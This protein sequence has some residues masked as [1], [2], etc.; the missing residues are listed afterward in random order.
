MSLGLSKLSW[1]QA[2]PASKM[3]SFKAESDAYSEG[4]KEQL[5]LKEEK[6]GGLTLG[7][8]GWSGN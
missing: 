5:L 3:T 2:A 4:S 8:L 1:W 6:K 7:S